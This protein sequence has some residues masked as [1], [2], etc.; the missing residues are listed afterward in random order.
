[1]I[2]IKRAFI[3]D[4]H[5]ISNLGKQTF[6]E[7]FGHLFDQDELG[8]YL[9]LTFNPEKLRISLSKNRNIF[10]ILYYFGKP[11]GYYKVKMGMDYNNLPNEKYSQLQRFTFLE[12]ICN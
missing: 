7:T 4:A 12:N 11:I 10:G 2:S 5:T 8:E 1:M 3:S 6:I 9:D